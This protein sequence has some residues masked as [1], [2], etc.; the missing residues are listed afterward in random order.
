MLNLCAIAKKHKFGLTE[1]IFCH[2]LKNEPVC[3]LL[4]T[5]TRHLDQ[6]LTMAS[7]NFGPIDC[8]LFLGTL[9]VQDFRQQKNSPLPIQCFRPSVYSQEPKTTKKFQFSRWLFQKIP[10]LYFFQHKSW[11]WRTLGHVMN[12]FMIGIFIMLQENTFG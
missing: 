1:E 6:T 5:M 3:T 12:I 9:H 10:F 11:I 7:P 2:S 4:V 8:R